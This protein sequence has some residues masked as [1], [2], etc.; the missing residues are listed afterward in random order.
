MWPVSP[1]PRRVTQAEIRATFARGWTVD[2]IDAE[3]FAAH[4]PGQGANAW[5]AL[6][7]RA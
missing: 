1:G 2:S 4:L 5:L 3:R 7:T 6:L